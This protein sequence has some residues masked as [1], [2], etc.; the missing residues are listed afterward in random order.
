[1]CDYVIEGTHIQKKYKKFTLNIEKLQIPKGYATALIGENGAGKTQC[2]LVKDDTDA[3][4]TEF[5][6]S[7][8]AWLFFY[9]EIEKNEYFFNYK[10]TDTHL[11][12]FGVL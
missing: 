1:M 6:P 2:H 3:N 4:L 8:S 9:G 5:K 12:K 7:E 11:P 10:K